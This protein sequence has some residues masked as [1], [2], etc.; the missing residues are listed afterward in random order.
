MA[1][2][3]R[4]PRR[5]P[6]SGL[7][8][9]GPAVLHQLPDSNDAAPKGPEGLSGTRRAALLEVDGLTKEYA[10]TLAVDSLSLRVHGGEILG[11]VGPN[12]AGKTTTLRTIAGVL[13]LEQGSV[14]IAG[15]DLKDS[16]REA[17]RRLAW[18]PDDPQP[19]DALTVDEHLEFVA[20]LY[21]V[22]DWRP[23]AEELLTRFE[24]IEKRSA[25]GGELSRGMRQKLAFCCAW[26][27]APE[28]V[29]LDEPLSGLDPRGIR[30]AKAAI[31]DLAAEGSAVVLSSHLLDLV[32][33]LGTRLAILDRGR[34]VFDGAMGQ[35]LEELSGDTRLEDV[36]FRVTGGD[37]G[38]V[39]E[40]A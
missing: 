28:V 33:E 30:S 2:W 4:P 37:D 36:F 35:A 23:R 39:E 29:L 27:P 3:R 31:R 7:R 13:P 25:L 40:R 20:A 24:L 26:L 32:Q 15:V 5:E 12:G 14:R 22:P 34:C 11:L 6:T 17:K 21:R 9:P 16:E 19:F 38:E 10:T 1:D 8:V 18:V